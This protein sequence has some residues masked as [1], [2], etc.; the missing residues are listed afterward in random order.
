MHD[1][2]GSQNGST[3]RYTH[4]GSWSLATLRS[5]ATSLNQLL[6]R[7]DELFRSWISFVVCFVTP[8]FIPRASCTP[9]GLRARS[10]VSVIGVVVINVVVVAA[11]TT[12]ATVLYIKE[13]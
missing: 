2:H 11:A 1:G 6:S 3:C 9:A 5:Y 4:Q 13:A 12:T 10:V 7:E 8:C